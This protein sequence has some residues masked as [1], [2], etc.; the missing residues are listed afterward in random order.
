MVRVARP[1][2][3]FGPSDPK[4]SA[5]YMPGHVKPRELR[6]PAPWVPSQATIPPPL[7]LPFKTHRSQPRTP[8]PAIEPHPA[9]ASAGPALHLLRRIDPD[10]VE[11]ARQSA[12][13]GHAERQP[14]L[15]ETR[16][17]G[18][19]H[20][21]VTVEG[22]KVR[23]RRGSVGAEPMRRAAGIAA[24][25][26][27]AGNSSRRLIRSRSAC[28]S[29]GA[30]AAAGLSTGSRARPGLAEDAGETGMGVLDV[31]DRIVLRLALGEIEIEVEGRVV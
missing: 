15:L 31:I 13:C 27:S 16:L 22:V 25:S 7:M 29:T 4:L 23:R 11:R 26:T 19:D 5:F 21:A 1:R 17:G 14:R 20:L 8:A 30:P 28:S 24:A 9:P 6:S 10:E 2:I 3:V 18:A 12:L